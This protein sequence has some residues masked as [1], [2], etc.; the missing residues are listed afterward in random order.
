MK[1]QISRLIQG[2]SPNLTHRAPHSRDEN[3]IFWK[4]SRV[5]KVIDAQ[6]KMNRYER[7]KNV[8]IYG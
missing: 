6:Q 2:Q 3:V 8:R 7:K 5:G 4:R 1:G